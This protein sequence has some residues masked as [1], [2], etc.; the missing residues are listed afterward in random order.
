MGLLRSEARA[1]PQALAVAYPALTLSLLTLLPARGALLF[2][3]QPGLADHSF[4][5]FSLLGPPTSDLRPLAL[6]LPD[7]LTALALAAA[8]L[9]LASAIA[10]ACPSPDDT[11]PLAHG[12]LAAALLQLVLAAAHRLTGATSIF[13]VS[14][15]PAWSRTD[16]FGSFVSPNH[17]GALLAASVPLALAA[18]RGLPGAG[19][20][21]L[22]SAGVLA[23][24][25]RG[26]LLAL[27]AGGLLYI[28]RT[29]SDTAR[30]AAL[31]SA[32]SVILAA[33]VAGPRRAALWLSLRIIPE[34]HLQ[35]LSGRRTEIWADTLALIRR[36]PWLGVGPGGFADGFKLARTSPVFSLTSQAHN[37]FLQLLAEAGVLAGALWLLAGGLAIGHAA[38]QPGRLSAGWVAAA[39]A[40][41]TAA[42]VD[43]PLQ[44]PA[45]S[46]L[47]AILLGALL[48]GAPARVPR[49]RAAGLAAAGLALLLVGGRLLLPHP[50]T[51][52][53]QAE[54]EGTSAETA[55]ALYRRA[56]WLA[57]QTHRALLGMGGL[58]WQAGRLDEAAEFYAVAAEGYPTLPWPWLNLARLRAAQGDLEGAAAAWQRMLA[59]N[60]PDNDNARPWL[61]EALALGSDPAWAAQHVLPAR[62]DRLRLGARMLTDRVDTP[63]TRAAAE[64][65]YQQ[66]VAL[67]PVSG[68]VYAG[69]LVAWKRPA[70]ALAVL[71]PLP[72]ELCPAARLAA[73]A[74]ALLGE[75]EEAR[76]RLAQAQRT[77]PQKE[78]AELAEGLLCVR[79]MLGEADALE[80]VA[81]RLARGRPDP[82]GQRALIAALVAEE[83]RGHPQ[84]ERLLD[85]LEVLILEGDATLAEMDAYSS[86]VAGRAI[87][88][89]GLGK[90][91]RGGVCRW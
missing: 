7:A 88:A 15:V 65:L 1:G 16:F 61:E 82:G 49:L 58:R 47:G 73:K 25:S 83:A 67:D 9:A 70:D 91:L 8:L 68:V 87:E 79:M 89:E 64:A 63:E 6:H 72:E 32:T 85:A 40:L 53:A 69:A 28:L 22:L 3:L 59:Q 20:A 34:D 21:V 55:E 71:A 57:P 33:I 48:A 39:A 36:S 62:A 76:R 81:A 27:A 18:V 31:I 50:D 4:H 23:T 44:I 17:A 14:G 51:L 75:H 66:A 19:L 2:I 38:R 30:M 78:Q 29:G 35:D 41:S 74:H 24:G 10:R 42:L 77:C 37:D 12:V 43:F 86:V 26:A 45:L 46:L 90:A 84:R 60:L 56:L 54:Q 52:T 13:W 80:K 5:I 11:R